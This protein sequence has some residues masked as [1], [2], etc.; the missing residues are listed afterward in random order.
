MVAQ[1]ELRWLHHPE[2]KVQDKERAPGGMIKQ[3]GKRF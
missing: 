2:Q 3:N 1:L